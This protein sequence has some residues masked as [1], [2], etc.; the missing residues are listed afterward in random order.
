MVL[1]FA[2]LKPTIAPPTDSTHSQENQL[3]THAKRSMNVTEAF[4]LLVNTN[5]LLKL[6]SPPNGSH[7]SNFHGQTPNPPLSAPQITGI[8]PSL[9]GGGQIRPLNDRQA[10][11]TPLLKFESSEQ[12]AVIKRICIERVVEFP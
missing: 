9:A 12:W 8:A 10:P 1:G 3:R 6:E 2:Q 4:M 11:F 5:E 7:L